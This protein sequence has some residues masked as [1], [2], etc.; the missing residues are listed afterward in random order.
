MRHDGQSTENIQI[1][2]FI[3]ALYI[4]IAIFAGATIF[5]ASF[6]FPWFAWVGLFLLL[7]VAAL[8]FGS[9]MAQEIEGK[10]VFLFPRRKFT[11]QFV[12]TV[13]VVIA[14]VVIAFFVA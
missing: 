1:S 3:Y 13:L 8:G 9:S 7:L 5:L 14:C 2:L 12:V 11:I 4:S 10:K 6:S